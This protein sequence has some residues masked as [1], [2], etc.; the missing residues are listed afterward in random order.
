MKG[1]RKQ[2]KRRSSTALLCA[3]LI[4]ANSLSA[5]LPVYAESPDTGTAGKPETIIENTATP[6]DGNH[7]A[8]NPGDGSVNDEKVEGVSTD[9][10][11]S[12]DGGSGSADTGSSED[13]DGGSADDNGDNGSTAGGNG[14]NAADNGDNGGDADGSGDNAT[15]PGDNGSAAGSDGG[16]ADDNGNNGDG[17]SETG[18]GGADDPDGTTDENDSAPETPSVSD[19]DVV[20][21]DSSLAL[22]PL[23]SAESPKT[24][25]TKKVETYEDS[26]FP[27]EVFRTYIKDSISISS[28]QT[29]TSDKLESLT[30]LDLPR[31]DASGEIKS[32]QGIEYLEN[33]KWIDFEGHS[34]TNIGGLSKLKNLTSLNLAY[35]DLTSLPNLSGMSLLT[36]A[37]FRGNLIAPDEI[38][39]EKFPASVLQYGTWD[40][41][42]AS[43]KAS[44]NRGE[45]TAVFASTYY[46]LEDTQPFLSQVTGLKEDSNRT[47][48]LS[49]TI[50]GKTASGDAIKAQ[51]SSQNQK[52]MYYIRDI[53]KDASGTAT[54]IAVTENVPCE[55]LVTLTDQYGN[56]PLKQTKQVTFAADP[57]GKPTADTQ[58]IRPDAQDVHINLHYLPSSYTQD[59]IASVALADAEGKQSG[60]ASYI[61]VSSSSYKPYSGIF[62]DYAI[63]ASAFEWRE[64]YLSCTINLAKYLAAGEYQAIVTCKDGTSCTVE[65][66]VTV[67]DTPIVTDV[68]AANYNYIDDTNME[69]DNHG[70]YLYV[71]L[72]GINIDPA[73][74]RPVFYDGG[75]TISAFVNVI[76]GGN[77]GNDKIYI[78]KLKKLE[79]DTYWN[80]ESSRYTYRIEADPGYDF[81]DATQDKTVY[82]GNLEKDCVVFEHYNYKKGVYEVKLD[83]RVA[84]GTKMSVS[85]YSD[86][87]Y[88][89]CEGT[90]EDTVTNGMLSLKFKNDAGYIYQPWGEMYF[91]YTYTN[92]DEI[93]KSF[94]HHVYNVPQYNYSNNHT[95]AYSDTVRC[96]A[97][98]LKELSLHVAV[99]SRYGAVETVTAT[100]ANSENG[101]NVGDSVTLTGGAAADGYVSYTGTWSYPAGLA[102]G[103]YNICYRIKA[104]K[105]S[106]ELYRH[107]LCIYDDGKFYMEDQSGGI[108]AD[109]TA[110]GIYIAFSSWQLAG[111]YTHKYNGKV[112]NDAAMTYWNEG[113]YQLELFDR[114]GNELSGWKTGHASWSGDTFSL[115]LTGLSEEY[116]GV[117]ARIS[118]GGNLGICLPYDG[119]AEKSYYARLHDSRDTADE[120]HGKWHD[121]KRNSVWLNQDNEL[122]QAYYGFGSYTY[123]VTV[124]ITRPYDTDVIQTF[125][126]AEPTDGSNY[127]FTETDLAQTEPNEV[128]LLSAVSADGSGSSAIGYLAVKGGSVVGSVDATGVTLNITTLD[129]QLQQTETL[130]A[131][132]TPANATNKTVTWSSDNT[133][134]A[135]VDSNGTVTAVGAG[136]ATITATTHN[137]KTAS[138]TVK[139][140]DKV[141]TLNHTSLRFNLSAE[142]N[143]TEMLQVTEGNAV[144]SGVTWSSTDESVA[145]VSEAGLVTPVG[146]GVTRIL[147]AIKNGPTLTC[148][149]T[150]SKDLTGV[151]L[152]KKSCTL[153]LNTKDK[154]DTQQLKIYV[155]PGDI[156]PEAMT[157][158]WTSDKPEIASVTKDEKDPLTAAVTAQSKGTA[159]ISVSVTAASGTKTAECN[160]TVKAAA[161]VDEGNIPTGL[162]A[163]TNEQLT[164]ANVKLPA[165][166]KWHT[167]DQ[168]VPLKQFAGAQSKS[169][170][171]QYRDP[172]DPDAEPYEKELSVALG[173]VTG[174]EIN[175]ASHSIQ[176]GSSTALSVLWNLTG[177][178]LDLSQ[179]GNR[180]AW[181]TDKP[182]VASLNGTSGSSVTLNTVGAGT[183]T[184]T[185]QVK[186]ADNTLYKAQ[187]KVTVTEGAP[188]GIQVTGVDGFSADT[189]QKNVYYATLQADGS[190]N[191]G[192]IHVT[193]T[194]AD[195]LTLKNNNAKVLQ[196][197]KP[198]AA[199]S[200]YRIPI[201]MKAAGTAKITLTANDAAK[202]Q[203]EIRLYVSDTRPNVSDTTVTINLQ[204]TTGATFTLYPCTGY[205]MVSAALAG[206]G[207]DQFSLDFD[208]SQARCLIKAKSTTAKGTYKLT[209]QGKVKDKTTEY[210]YENVPLTVK[211]ADQKPN[212]KIKQTAKVNLFYTNW[213]NSRLTVTTDETLENLELTDCD[214]TIEKV[215]GSYI[216]KAKN[217]VFTTS[218]DKKGTLS[219]RFAGYQEITANFTV[220]VEEKAPGCKFPA[221]TVT[222][223]PD[224][225]LNSAILNPLV[226]QPSGKPYGDVRYTLDDGTS[227]AGFSL[228]KDETGNFLIRYAGEG[229]R[230]ATYHA[231]FTLTH[232][233]WKKA[234]TVPLTVKISKNTPAAKLSKKTLQLNTGADSMAY[235]AAATAVMW[236]D[237]AAFDPAG[238]SVSATNAKSQ[239]IINTGIVFRY[240]RQKQQ[241][242]AKL[243]NT[244]VAKGS[245]LFQVNI[246]INDTL[247]V[248]T[249]LTIKVID[250]AM[251]NAVKI[252]AKGAIDVLNRAGTYVTVTP[253]LQS[254]NGTITDVRL[255]GSA[256]HLFSAV[257][258]DN[259][260]RIYARDNA[261]LITKYG[262]KVKLDLT[263]EN[264]TGDSIRYTTQDVTLK[265][266][267]GKPKVAISPKSLTLYSGTS[268]AVT[269]R[270]SA[271]LKGREGELPIET[272]ELLNNT[273]AFQCICS[274]TENGTQVITLKNTDEIVKGKTYP[275]QLRVTFR[276]QAD[277]EKATVIRYSVKVK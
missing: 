150:V 66:A 199:E 10:G 233:T 120:T 85:V 111:D 235:D 70:D 221:K 192:A 234:V 39:R 188:A 264:A 133:A 165:G 30:R 170:L 54:G 58:Y 154:P 141:Y 272:V 181:S 253:S 179:Y 166:W 263:M 174:I 194:G 252:S 83:S 71:E 65:N 157:I 168:N 144:I 117:Y 130:A 261:A 51:N 12:E 211:V 42:L 225:G 1:I 273:D 5:C 267:Q 214:F 102:E 41:Y 258:E 196:A 4:I 244:P 277:N 227:A 35:N 31:S 145:T 125:T 68:R 62:D 132:V 198:T 7:S 81:I 115:Y 270:I 216:L 123:P 257:C 202:T 223:Y 193:V 180:V 14:D 94:K 72:R 189:Q 17:G 177:A 269:R 212:Y 159:K 45:V 226:Y 9:T 80:A 228:G 218:Y 106:G 36:S 155:T 153:Y 116:T 78:Y 89:T 197:G 259:K 75:V 76:P 222:L 98:P 200:G 38:T 204:Q 15:V 243:N 268:P 183:A 88:D 20:S 248:S 93:V 213:E 138:C 265:L 148:T 136:T 91:K 217:S 8:V 163:L 124:T 121:L 151:T 95:G 27:D 182:A 107:D 160:V 224:K 240:D 21:E 238:V 100:I 176:K 266:K 260:I 187:Y 99:P 63:P 113:G 220:G 11:S 50:D 67:S 40:E 195:K 23:G 55:V 175:A 26:V 140:Y 127:D 64:R 24:F 171:A 209:L 6:N 46:A 96:H 146:A 18:T 173:I 137:G 249:P 262:Y 32:L 206:N 22:V 167:D 101:N 118:K 271:T 139:V 251:A 57:V 48:T 79:K 237:G 190:D 109:Q 25:T 84:D 56:T 162:T 164:L 201:T 126:V 73:K 156:P 239:A 142:P 3:V 90:A 34:I 207:A 203:A 241:V 29:I 205:Q 246:R 161:T 47:Y 104:A 131:T 184:V 2:H 61:Q 122:T 245:Y 210:S 147:A 232:G 44:C 255:S 86:S 129:M 52:G 19:N 152:D 254:I 191:T 37:D 60:A 134:V 231:N 169:F 87:S 114:T 16:S 112:S 215:N 149:V 275:L 49:L 82:L 178:Q 74:I 13:S 143:H 229:G 208:A 242:I 69:Y 28:W 53:L 247:T 236:K 59:Q 274:E 103:R 250:T 186:F 105:F 158:T 119:E 219:L 33:L 43:C 135:T 108:W 172:Q 276:D 230:N 185:A 97:Q 110:G 128:Y 256:A 77:S 92:Q